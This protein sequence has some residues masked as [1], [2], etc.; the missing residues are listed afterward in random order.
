[1]NERTVLATDVL[2]SR[3]PWARGTLVKRFKLL[4]HKLPR[5]VTTARLSDR[6]SDDNGEK[7]HVEAPCMNCEL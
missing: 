2:T 1:M 7:K 4:S 5:L 3:R 6:F